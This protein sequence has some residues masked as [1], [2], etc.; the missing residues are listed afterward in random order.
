MRRRVGD[1][2]LPQPAQQGPSCRRVRLQEAIEQGF[3]LVGQQRCQLAK[4]LLVRLFA[5]GGH[6]AF[7]PGHTRAHNALAVELFAGQL[8]Q[9]GRFIVF[10]RACQQPG[11][12]GIH[13]QWASAGRNPK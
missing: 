10:E 12:Q 7:Q 13:I 6:K 9:Q 3:A 2:F 1:G 5:R 8:Q 11:L 4:G